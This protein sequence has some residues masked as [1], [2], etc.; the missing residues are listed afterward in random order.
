LSGPWFRSEPMAATRLNSRA[1]M[2]ANADKAAATRP[3]R[4]WKLRLR[5]R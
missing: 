1:A 4:R 5:G 3:E 2:E